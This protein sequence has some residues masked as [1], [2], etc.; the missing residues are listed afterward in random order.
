VIHVSLFAID[1]RMQRFI[2]CQ[3]EFFTSC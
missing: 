3:Y 2:V 1:N